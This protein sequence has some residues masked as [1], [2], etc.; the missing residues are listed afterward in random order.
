MNGGAI[1]NG[2]GANRRECSRFAFGSSSSVA[3]S[4]RPRIPRPMERPRAVQSIHATE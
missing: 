2:C 1:A 3:W 4:P